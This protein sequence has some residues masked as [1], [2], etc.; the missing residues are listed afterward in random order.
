VKAQDDP[1]KGTIYEKTF[2]VLEPEI[3]KLKDLMY[4][5]RDTV[6][7]VYCPPPHR[8]LERNLLLQF[9]VVVENMSSQRLARAI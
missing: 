7:L 6:K 3:K 8:F 5:M 9:V 1:N 4:F 2:E